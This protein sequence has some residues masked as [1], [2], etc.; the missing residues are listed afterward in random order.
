MHCNLRL[1][2]VAPLANSAF[3]PSEVSKWVPASACHTWAP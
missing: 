2:D 3:Y 1:P